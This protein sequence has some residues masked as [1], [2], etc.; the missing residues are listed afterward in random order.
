MMKWNGE[1]VMYAH[2]YV[3]PGSDIWLPHENPWEK[4][5]VGPLREMV[6]SQGYAVAY[7][8]FSENGWAVK[9]GITR[10][11]QLKGI[12]K[13]HFGKPEKTYLICASMG[14]V[15]GVA[16]AE[17]H[18]E[19]VDGVL[20]I[21]GAVAGPAYQFAHI[22]HTRALFNLFYPE[23]IPGD[24]Y[25]NPY[26]ID[27]GFVFD[28]VAIGDL[29]RND[30]IIGNP[31]AV[32]IAEID[33]VYIEWLDPAELVESIV[34]AL[35]FNVNGT[36]D[37]LDRT[38]GHVPVGNSDT[39]YTHTPKPLNPLPVD[40]VFVNA[41]VER[42]PSTPDA[43]KYMEH[44]YKPSGK[45]RIPVVTLHTTR[46]PAVP[47]SHQDVFADAVADSGKNDLLREFSVPLF[48]HCIVEPAGP[49]FAAILEAWDE[50][51]DMV[52]AVGE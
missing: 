45:L 24:V 11:R 22:M 25:D 16:I 15:I 7:S 35:V 49:W 28:P 18:S 39:V 9:D 4:D 32:W 51:L 38:H 13:S 29:I 41:W 44:W 37:I 14:G 34:T 30:L 20:S 36:E 48:G 42:I 8:S 2:G 5:V 19:L 6:L 12:F 46:D 26:D 10:T 33:Q 27:E 17:K 3:M 47:Y 43:E 31:R 21:C 23:V 50:L 40:P 52:E 1:L